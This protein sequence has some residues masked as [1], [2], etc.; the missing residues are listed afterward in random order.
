MLQCCGVGGG[1]STAPQAPQLHGT[2]S[3]VGATTSTRTT[4]MQDAVLE[5]ILEQMRETEA[6]RAELERQHAD[7]QNQL[8]EKIAGRYQGPESVEALQS[9]IR[10]LEKK[11]ELQMVKHEELSLELTS[12]RRA[13][14]RGPGHVV[15]LVTSANVPTSTW[16]PAGSEIDRIIA[17]I[18][19]DNSAGRIL[20]ELDHSRGT[21]T[22]QQPSATQGILRSS[23]ENLPN[24]GQHQHPPHPHALNLGMPTQMGHY[25]GSP[26]PLTPMM[27]GC[28]P[29]TPNG[30]PY[31]YSEPIPPA[32][33]LSSSQS[34]PAFQQKIQQYQQQQQS[35]HEISS[36]HSQSVLPSQQKQTHTSHFTSNQYQ[37]S[38]PH[39]QTYQQPLQQQQQ[40]QQQQ[41]QQQQQHPASTTYLTSASQSVIPHYTQPAQTAQNYQLNGS[42]QATTYPS[43]SMASHPNGTYSTGAT[44]YNTQLAHH[45]YTGPQ[46][47]IPQTTLSSLPLYSTTFHST[48]GG[49]TSVPQS[50]LP[51]STGQSTFAT[52]GSTYSTTVGTNAF[53]TSGVSSGTSSGGLLQAIGDPLQAMQQLSAQSQA[54]QLQQQAIIQQIQQSLRASSPTAPGTVTGHHFLGPRQM[55]KIPTSILTNPLDRLT[56]TED[57]ISEGQV[58]MLDVP[59][60]GRCYVYIARFSY[61]PFQ[62][63]PNAN[64]EAELPVQGGDYLLVW[65]QPDEDGF[66]DA[67]TLDGRRGLVPANFVQKLVGDDLLEFHQAVLGLRD[68]DDSVSTNIPQCYLQDI[69]LELAAL[70]EGNR[71]RQ[72]ELTAYAELDNIAEEDE[73]EPPEVYMFSDLVPAPQHLTLERQL[74]KSVL[75]GWTAPDNTHQL[76]SYHVYVDGVL[77]VTVKA[78]ERTRALVEGVDSTRPH[79]ISV[80]SVTHSR[81]TSRDAAC[82][83]VIGKD[84]A[85]GPTAV[86]ASNVT[87]TSAVISWLP[88]NSNHQHVVCVN[89]VE[90]RTVKPGVYRHTITGLAPSTI[91]RV[92]VKAKN[93]RAT[94]FEDQNTQAANNLACHVHFKTLPKGLPDPPV[95]IQ[96]EAGPQDGTLLVTWQPVALNGSAV[97]GYA[98]YADGKKVTDVDSPTGDHALVDIHKLMGLNPKHITVRTKSRES[99]SG[100]SCATAIPCSVLRGGAAAA[101]PHMPPS[102]GLPHMVDQR[103]PPQSTMGPQQ[104]D[105]NRHRMVGGVSQRYPP[106]A[107]VPSH[108]RRHV[109]NR[110]DA[111]GQVIIETD[112]NLSD[113][114]IYP[115]QSIPQMGIPEITKDSASEANYSEEDD[116]TRR[117]RGMPPQHHG[118]QHR[119]GAQMDPQGPPGAHRSPSMS[120]PSS[121]PQDPYYDQTGASQRGR[122]PVY[123]R[124]GRVPQAQG[125]ASHPPNVAQQMNKRQRWFVALFDYDPTTMSPNPD[126]CEEELPFSEGDTIK[127]YGEKDADGFYWGECRGRRGYVPY[128]MVEELKDPPGQGQP[129]RRGPAQNERWGDIYASMPVKK[130]IALYDY[131]PHELS[132][133]VDAQVELTF[134][135]GN[136]IYVYGDMDDDGFYMGELNG[137]R[138]LVP[139]NFLTE[140]PGQNQGQPPQGSRRPGGQSQGPGARGPPPPPREPPPAGHRRGKDACI[141][142]VSVP[143]CHLDSR[144]LQQQPPPSLMN[145]QQHQLQ[146]QNN[147]PHLA[148]QQANHHSY[149]TV[150]TSNQHGPS[151]LPPG[152]GVMGAHQQGPVPP[153]LQQQGK[154]RGGVVN[155]IAGSN[156]PGMQGPGQQQDYQSQQQM[157]QPY[158]QQPNQPYQQQQ[159]NQGYPQQSTQQFQQSQ[160]QQQMG[161]PFSQ[162]N[163]PGGLGM[164]IGGP[165]STSKPMRG[166][167]A[168]LPTAQSKTQPNTMQQQQQQQQP[169]QQ[170]TG[171]NLMQKFT[172][173][174]GA[175]AGGDILSKGKELIFMKFGLGK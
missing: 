1:A 33:S 23:S 132:P 49:L 81:R 38:Y 124:G 162:Q 76:E 123:G 90:V 31:H 25:A 91:Y 51:Y 108:M 97:T 77:K 146:H 62:H 165:Q 16:P 131:D 111:H 148:Y 47:N 60:K 166:I 18:E 158:Q 36:S 141:V 136:E 130:M 43:L 73:Q 50:V 98:V 156:M 29:L 8:R 58:D 110:V 13:R 11:T 119:Y 64:P 134:Q 125:G 147:P 65:G 7:A 135:T 133:N 93:L 113:K 154:G 42:Q 61:E 88:S 137:V 163:Q 83:M 167:P 79:R 170:S 164:Q 159:P 100:D 40:P 63:S 160:P 145:N 37:E 45:N 115:G 101:V 46:T 85:L 127:V 52:S 67:E 175:S 69:D 153:H 118:P 96:V 155:R 157:N 128:N 71:N 28:P 144:Q 122:G 68:V 56:N 142:P 116:P 4:I 30:P 26:M 20:H 59:G 27:P 70:E 3:A 9:K 24:L 87:A 120:G 168:V 86:K 102:H 92:T 5:S 95:D 106:N 22:T 57:I 17:K 2:G 55:P 161:Q 126:A 151:H 14:S 109:S 121:R 105:P 10:E 112:E 169:Q 172:E 103:Q 6:Q 34:Q 173:M 66:L 174:A 80:R 21:I 140:A 89:N 15:G 19:Q 48:L 39:T 78:T 99:Q 35:Q 150:T 149:T 41:P 74:N 82:T 84:I 114:E 104:D 138:G 75:I 143:V 129:G 72:A 32:P 117:S 107:P 94:H 54:N 12:L 44:T 139:S 53:G 171:P 152:G